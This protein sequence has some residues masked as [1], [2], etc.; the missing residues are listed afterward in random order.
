MLVVV[1]VVWVDL[2]NPAL[3]VPCMTHFMNSADPGA[4]SGTGAGSVGLGGGYAKLCR[5]INTQ[6]QYQR[7]WHSRDEFGRRRWRPLDYCDGLSERNGNHS[8]MAE[9]PY[10]VNN[11]A[12]GGGRV[13]FTMT[14]ASRVIARLA[15]PFKYLGEHLQAL[16]LDM[17]EQAL[18]TRSAPMSMR[19]CREP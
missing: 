7:R 2:V 3:L 6:R 19:H 12:G 5:I 11:G 16:L 4:G 14:V 17:A 15:Q 9:I 1:M 18:C 13:A 10:E 8:P